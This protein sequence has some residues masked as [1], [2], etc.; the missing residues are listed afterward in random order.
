MLTLKIS[1]DD[2]D[3]IFEIL[4]ALLDR[5]KENGDAVVLSYAAPV[6]VAF[7]TALINAKGKPKHRNTLLK[8]KKTS[9]FN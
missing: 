6:I 7:G 8:F 3:N 1:E 5:A 4:H 9:K 2:A